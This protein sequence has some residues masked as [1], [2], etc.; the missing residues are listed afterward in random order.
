MLDNLRRAGESS[1]VLPPGWE[2]YGLALS[3]WIEDYRVYRAIWVLQVY[4]DLHRATA[5][6]PVEPNN[7]Q[8]LSWGGWSWDESEVLDIPLYAPL[9]DIRQTVREEVETVDQI[10][11]DLVTSTK[12]HPP[13]LDL[14]LPFFPSLEMKEG[15]THPLWPALPMPTI[16]GVDSWKR[17]KSSTCTAGIQ[18]QV[19]QAIKRNSTLFES[20][21]RELQDRVH[22]QDPVPLQKLGIFL[23]DMW[24]VWRLTAM[25][26]CNTL[27]RTNIKAPDGS[28]MSPFQRESRTRRPKSGGF[29]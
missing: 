17:S 29:G 25:G 16:H 23:W 9:G 27:T 7:S 5:S 18:R 19:F 10:L 26:Y 12:V 22:I 11:Q 8:E 21:P 15:V 14:H 6:E 2:V 3:S 1:S 24:D 28:S 13:P 4:S 20:D